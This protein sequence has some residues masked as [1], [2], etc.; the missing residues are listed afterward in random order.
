MIHR[1]GVTALLLTLAM[2]AEAAPCWLG[3]LH[4]LAGT[5]RSDTGSDRSEERWIIAP[6]DRLMGSAWLLHTDRPGGVV[7]ASTIQ[8]DGETM[9]LRI[10]HFSGDLATAR[11]EKDAPMLFT[12]AGCEADEIT[13]DGQGPQAG[14]HMRY[15]RDGDTLHFTGDFIHQGKPLRV[16]LEFKRTGD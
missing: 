9:A 5:W 1:L 8:S 4:W 6:G 14:E 13:L 10:R 2:P 7:E 11:E 3:D 12:A 16:E 15:S